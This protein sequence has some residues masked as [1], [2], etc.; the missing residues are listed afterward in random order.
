MSWLK[1][2][3]SLWRH[4]RTNEVPAAALGLWIRAGSLTADQLDNGYLKAKEIKRYLDGRPREVDALVDAGLW[5]PV[6][7]GEFQFVMH[8]Y[9]QYNPTAEQV[10]AR[11]DHDRNRQEEW[12]ATQ[13]LSR[14][15]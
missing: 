3:D 2:S 10:R 13:R 14:R 6:S 8:D 4:R 5:L 1:V 9:H 15:D 12:R 7:G 11:R